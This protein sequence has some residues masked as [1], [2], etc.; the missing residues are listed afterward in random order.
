[1]TFGGRVKIKDRS[2]GPVKKD[3]FQRETRSNTGCLRTLRCVGRK[4]KTS[5]ARYLRD[6]VVNRGRINPR[7]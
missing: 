1:M 2:Y 3:K 7:G 5:L 4:K 6:N